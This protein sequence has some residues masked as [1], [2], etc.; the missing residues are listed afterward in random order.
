M[1]AIYK[2]ELRSYFCSMTGY[3]FIVAAMIFTGIYFMVNNLMMGIPFFSYT[4]E[5]ALLI[6]IIIV[7]ILT[8]RSLADERHSK[9]DQLLL[10]SPASVSSIVIGKYLA[11][12][13]VFAIP[14]V[15]FC[16]CPLII[17]TGGSA[18][19]L[20]DYM[21]IFCTLCIGALFVA[22][23]MFISSLTENQ[24]ISAV[25]TLVA[26]MLLYMWD[27]LI[28]LLPTTAIGSLICSMIILALVV[29]AVWLFSKNNI[30]TIILAAV[31]LIAIVACYSIEP[32]LFDGLIP[33]LLGSFSVMSVIYNFS[34]Y[35][36][37]DLGGLFMLLSV[38]A[39]F[40][41]LTVQTIQ[42]RRWS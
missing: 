34:Y 28:S 11:M 35:Y 17:A 33:N 21:S 20:S 41:F 8:M 32:T 30:I 36:V 7:P 39:M 24:I 12:M 18:H 22:I 26:L 23:G 19:L 2:R 5:N 3:I 27:S 37:F 16:V 40:V 29:L 6:Y 13:T 31:G 25:V 4:L 15:I 38:A 9:T 1:L 14:M 10:T 42:K